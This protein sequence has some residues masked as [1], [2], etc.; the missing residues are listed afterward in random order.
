MEL[1]LKYKLISK[2]ILSDE[3][4]IYI[5]PNEVFESLKEKIVE[6]IEKSYTF[7]EK[8]TR[9]VLTQYYRHCKKTLLVKDVFEELIQVEKNEIDVPEN[10]FVEME[11]HVYGIN[12]LGKSYSPKIKIVNFES[13]NNKIDFLQS[14]QSDQSDS[15]TNSVS[16]YM[17]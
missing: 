7:I 10:T 6:I 16:E 5:K 15:D 4:Y 2:V 8:S 9:V 3:K 14:D 12:V 1:D 11:F 17:W 13:I